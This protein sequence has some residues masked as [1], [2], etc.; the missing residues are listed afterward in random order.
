MAVPGLK[1]VDKYNPTV[2]SEQE[3][4]CLEATL[5]TTV[6]SDEINLWL[7]SFAALGYLL[8]PR[9]FF[10]NPVYVGFPRMSSIHLC[11]D[12]TTVYWD[13]MVHAQVQKVIF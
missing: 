13:P 8:G 10:E 12:L 5:T 7:P 1:R 6:G 9:E 2:C 4:W 3:S 11:I